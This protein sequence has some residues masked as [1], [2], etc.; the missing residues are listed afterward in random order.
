MEKRSTAHMIEP[1]IYTIY[2]LVLK[3]GISP[4]RVLKMWKDNG[5]YT[6]SRG[7]VKQIIRDRLEAYWQVHG[8]GRAGDNLTDPEPT[9]DFIK[10][11]AY[12]PG[13]FKRLFGG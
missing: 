11:Y 8:F 13:F 7:T 9:I 1:E 6:S 3:H 10:R 4:Q 2:M 5:H 12:R